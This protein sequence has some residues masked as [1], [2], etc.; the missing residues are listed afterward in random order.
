MTEQDVITQNPRDF[1]V[2]IRRSDAPGTTVGTGV[3]VSM[4]QIVTCAHVAWLSTGLDPYLAIG[5]EIPVYFSQARPGE[6]KSRTARIAKAFRDHADDV[7]LLELTGGAAPLGPEQIAKIDTAAQSDGNP[8][9]AYGYRP[10]DS[11]P[12]SWAE[13][14]IM[15]CVECPPN[16]DLQA[17]PVQLRSQEIAPGMSGAP[18]LDQK[19]NLVVG[20]V[21]E[22]YFPP[23]D[24]PKNRDTAWAVDARV[25]TFDPLNLPVQ[26]TV[27][28]KRAAPQ[29]PELPSEAALLRPTEPT[30]YHGAPPLLDEWVGRASLLRALDADWASPDTH[31]TTLIGFGGEGKSSLARQWVEK[32]VTS[33]KSKVQSQSAA[34]D[35]PRCDGL[36]WWNFYDSPNV[37]TFLEAILDYLT[38]GQL[39]SRSV[40]SASAKAPV[41]ARLL[42]GGR[43]VLV[44]DGF[45]VMQH[46]GAADGASGDDY[47]LVRSGDLRRF[48]EFVAAPGH[49][50]FCLITSRAPV[51][52][53]LPYTTA[54]QRDVTRL[55]AEDGRALLRAVGVKGGGGV[56]AP[57]TDLDRV[58]AAWDGHALTLSL[59]GTYLAERYDGDVARVGD[60][61]APTADEPRYARVHRV[62][63]RYDDHL[64]A[65]EREFLTLFSAFRT[66]VGLDAF[67]RVFGRQTRDAVGAR[68][69]TDG[70]SDAENRGSRASPLRTMDNTALTTM[71]TRLVQYRLLRHIPQN[72]TYTTHPLVRAHYYAL[73]TAG[74]DA[75]NAHNDIKAYYLDLA[76]DTPT[77]PTLADLRPLIEVVHHA[78]KAGAYDEALLIYRGRIQQGDLFVDIYVL[79]AYETSLALMLEFF[80]YN[81]TSQDPQVSHPISKCWILAAVGFRLM[82][83]GRLR[84][85][86][87]FYER[88]VDNAVEAEDW[89]NASAGY[90]HLTELHLALG[91]LRQSVETAREAFT[92]GRQGFGDR[93]T[94]QH[95]ERNSLAYIAWATHV[96]GDLD[97]ASEAFAKAEALEKETDSRKQYLYSLR[98]IQHADHL[99]RL[100]TLP[101]IPAPSWSYSPTKY[102]HL[103]TEANLEICEYFRWVKSISQCHRILGDLDSGD[104]HHDTARIHYDEALRIARSISLRFV[105]IE[106]LLARG[107]WVAQMCRRDVALQRLYPV[108][109]A[110]SDLEEALTYILPGGYRIYEADARV[111]LAWAHLATGNPERARQEAQRALTLSE[112]MGYY[113]GK[114]DAEEVLTEVV[115]REG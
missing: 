55:N 81:D 93:R 18:V 109:Q 53:L 69:A 42:H 35:V 94:N 17:E 13:G 83:L 110:F 73:F 77:Y 78:C 27:Q 45:E 50:S 99:R 63:R 33:P 105:L 10:M 14:T 80:P 74:P 22:T 3:A 82:G 79:G 68:H 47:G 30:D 108:Q 23:P 32:L 103:I 76:G 107:R 1:A 67:D 25:L 19:R 52:D 89:R 8:F 56:P 4:D 48:L 60:I 21:T 90:Q 38:G 57:D 101:Y 2:Q 29:P 16:L 95:M 7:V 112:G 15:G 92:L 59:L 64:T 44:L 71:V 106:A 96:R 62:L 88:A 98:G 46:A 84:E 91:D 66:P 86:V 9:R 34:K 114:V 97:A 12:A 85:A 111:A 39:D 28:P 51:L 65:A 61:P 11:H 6:E 100:A 70:R 113:W 104:G 41:V 75:A 24:D 87:P 49:G 102:A 40:P 5:T 31:V 43:Y 20:I 26:A 37:D 54:T 72:D 58:V 36:F 115:L